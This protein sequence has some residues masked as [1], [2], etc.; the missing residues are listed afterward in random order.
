MGPYQDV[1]CKLLFCTMQ[2]HNAGEE[3]VNQMQLLH[4]PPAV[5]EL[6]TLSLQDSIAGCAGRV[7][8]A[9]S[10][11]SYCDKPGIAIKSLQTNA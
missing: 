3:G 1:L 4:D 10:T 7:C 5:N 11:E 8:F 9:S 2:P 6:V